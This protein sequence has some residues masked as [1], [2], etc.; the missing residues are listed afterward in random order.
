LRE[1]AEKEKTRLPGDTYEEWLGTQTGHPAKARGH[2][3]NMP[4]SYDIWIGKRVQA[5]IQRSG[6]KVKRVSR[7]PK[8]KVGK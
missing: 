7:A 8:R 4:T 2:E 6:A 1:S 3:T 5:E